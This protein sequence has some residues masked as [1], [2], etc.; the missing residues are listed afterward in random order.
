MI[1]KPFFEKNKNKGE[2]TMRKTTLLLVIL[3][4]FFM[5]SVAN[6]KQPAL[7]KGG[8]ELGLQGSF[9]LEGPG[10]T[11]IDTAIGLGYF[12]MDSLEVGG[13]VMYDYT[14]GDPHDSTFFGGGIFAD[15]NIDFDSKFVPFVGASIDY[16]KHDYGEYDD[17]AFVIGG[18]V[19]VKYFVTNDWAI[20]ANVYLNWA[21]ED[22][23]VND[24]EID[25][26]NVGLAVGIRTFF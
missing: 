17:D 10:G 21:N 11:T 22:I 23:Y 20:S 25:D 4:C 19:G 3:A 24:G 14:E 15:Y 7:L 2:K 1:L 18:R 12:L 13:K 8:W 16:V 5:V 6:A 9:D 26:I